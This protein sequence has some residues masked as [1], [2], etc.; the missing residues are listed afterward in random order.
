MALKPEASV[1]AGVAVMAMVYGIHTVF[2]PTVA[3]IQ[4][5]P[6]GN[7]DGV[8]SEKKATWLSIGVVSGVSLLSKDPTVF[9]LGSIATVGMAFFTRHAAFTDTKTAMSS[10]GQKAQSAVSA[11]DLSEGPQMTTQDY[12]MFGASE[13]VSS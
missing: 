9:V 6:A 7:A 1:V 4:A 10:L 5:L 3:D 2:H 13:F 12:Q 8:D 11:N